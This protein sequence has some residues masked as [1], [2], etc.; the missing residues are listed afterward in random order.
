[1][2]RAITAVAT[3]DVQIIDALPLTLHPGDQVSLSAPSPERPGYRW[4]SDGGLC[5]GWVPEAVLTLRD[6]IGVARSEYCSQELP[7]RAG[8]TL[9]LMWRGEGF[10]ACWCESDDGERGWVPSDALSIEPGQGE[11]G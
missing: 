5:S 3:R 7:V 6:P 11:E 9:R 10:P 1:M 2:L 4:A 8:Q